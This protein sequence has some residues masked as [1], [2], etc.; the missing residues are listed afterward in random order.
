M[1]TYQ[2]NIDIGGILPKYSSVSSI[3]YR[4]KNKFILADPYSRE[5]FDLTGNS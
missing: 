5:D 4:I 3:I 2:S 1:Q